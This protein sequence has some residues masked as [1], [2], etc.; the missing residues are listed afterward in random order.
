MAPLRKGA[1]DDTADVTGDAG[2]ENEDEDEEPPPPSAYW[3]YRPSTV[4][5]S[6]ANAPA[7][8]T[9]PWG[10]EI[11]IGTNHLGQRP[12]TT[13]VSRKSAWEPELETVPS[14]TAAAAKE[15]WG[16]VGQ[17]GWGDDSYNEIGF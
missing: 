9:S 12:M 8:M 10:G 5:D 3:T 2:G 14:S 15:A 16:A 11:K 1:N 13:G 17:W 7:P 4:D 6:A